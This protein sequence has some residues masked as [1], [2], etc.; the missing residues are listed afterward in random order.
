MKKKSNYGAFYD[1][2][3]NNQTKNKFL[4]S[5]NIR[6]NIPAEVP[7]NFINPFYFDMQT[8]NYGTIRKDYLKVPNNNQS[9]GPKFTVPFTTYITYTERNKYMDNNA[10]I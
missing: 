8:N 3:A 4:K 9:I 1:Q 7:I 2:Q 6:Q 10:M 5:P